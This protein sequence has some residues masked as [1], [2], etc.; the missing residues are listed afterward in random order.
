MTGK[1]NIDVSSR[2]EITDIIAR[3][4]GLGEEVITKGKYPSA[5][6]NSVYHIEGCTVRLDHNAPANEGPYYCNIIIYGDAPECL[7]GLMSLKHS[8][9][10]D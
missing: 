4:D 5:H 9:A 6:C 8:R 2:A 3:M 7:L 1:F 10:C